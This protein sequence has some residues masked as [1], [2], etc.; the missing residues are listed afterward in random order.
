MMTANT[1]EG[2]R[3]PASGWRRVPA[4]VA[5]GVAS[6]FCIVV[7][8]LSVAEF[9]T[10]TA[11]GILQAQSNTDIITGTLIAIAPFVLTVGGCAAIISSVFYNRYK[12]SG[13]IFGSCL[14]IAAVFLSP[15]YLAIPIGITAISLLV[16]VF[17]GNAGK[18]LKAHIPAG[19]KLDPAGQAVA[20]LLVLATV[21]LL[22]VCLVLSAPWLPSES[23]QFNNHGPVVGYVLTDSGR[24][25]TILQSDRII[26]MVADGAVKKQAVCARPPLLGNSL[27]YI[28]RGE[29]QHSHR[30][31]AC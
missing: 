4:T 12:A 27:A 24:E 7:R 6:T 1:T 18:W 16:F 11:Y 25:M 8:L 5:I 29:L 19:Q 9:N 10:E 15:L 2:A 31:A 14:E 30:Y 21:A 20:E 28:I 3:R 13:I 23:F 17:S 26:M 22:V